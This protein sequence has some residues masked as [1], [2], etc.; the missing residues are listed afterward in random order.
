MKGQGSY[1]SKNYEF[2]SLTRNHNVL[3]DMIYV[4]LMQQFC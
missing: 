4:R 1:R 2:F 3:I